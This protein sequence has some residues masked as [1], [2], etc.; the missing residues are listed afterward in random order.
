[1][2][3]ILIAFIITYIVCDKLFEKFRW[4]ICDQIASAC[5]VGEAMSL[6]GLLMTIIGGYLEYFSFILF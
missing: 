5:V 3:E 2:L 1:M 6:I 4:R